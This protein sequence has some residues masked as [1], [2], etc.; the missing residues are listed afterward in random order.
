M[1]LKRKPYFADNQIKRYLVQLLACFSGYQ[2]KTG[3]QRDGK[4]RF[5]DVPIVYGDYSQVAA[6]IVRG[7]SDNTMAYLPIA[8]LYMTGLEQNADLRHFA[9]HSEKFSYVKRAE[10]ADGN[11][12]IN[13]PGEKITIERFMP[14]PYR[15][16]FEVS[17]WASNNDQGY[18]LVEQLMTVFNPDIDIQISNS[19]ADWT[20][21]STIL[22]QGQVRMEKAVP[23]G[24]DTNPL[25]VFTLPFQID[26]WMSPPAQV[27]ATK[28]IYR[29][30]VPILEMDGRDLEGQV[31]FDRLEQLDGLIIRADEA[32]ILTFEQIGTNP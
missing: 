3:N 26:I 8:A 25:Y 13:Q 21:L 9:Q 18:Q 23:S 11:L 17:F 22:F 28:H 24:T 2:V 1:A 19:P 16:T 6:Y 10:D 15:M 20:Q 31:D 32:D 27:Y 7:G 4:P 29:I 30:H 12:L 5:L 14:V